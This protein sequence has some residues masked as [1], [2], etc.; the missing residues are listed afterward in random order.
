M[1][2]NDPD[3]KL[4]ILTPNEIKDL[5]SIPHFNHL[6]RCQY[7]ELN[8]DETRLME[9][10]NTIAT[11]VYFILLLGYFKVKPVNRRIQFRDSKD[12]VRFIIEQYF[13][14]TTPPKGLVSKSTHYHITN[15]ILQV[16]N[17]KR[18]NVNDKNQLALR[19]KDITTITMD[20]RYIMDE[21]LKFIYDHSLVL[22]PY[23]FFQGIISKARISERERLE[24]IIKKQLSTHCQD[25]LLALLNNN[26]SMSA[27]ASIKRPPKDFSYSQLMQEVASHQLIQP[28]YSE[29]K[30]ATMKLSLSMANLEYYGSLVEY[31]SITKLR[32][33]P[34][35]RRL[36][37][38][39]C[40]MH[41]R[42]QQIND[43][44]LTAFQYW[45][46]KHKQASKEYGKKQVVE[47]VDALLNDM[48]QAL[49]FLKLFVDDGVKD[50]TPFGKVRQSGFTQCP[51][52]RLM[53]ICSQ[54]EALYPERKAYEWRYFDENHPQ[55]KSILR[56]L[57]ISMDFGAVHSDS[58]LYNQITIS[59]SELATGDL[60]TF[61]LRLLTKT[62][63]PHIVQ[64]NTVI[65]KRYEF[66]LYYRISDAIDKGELYVK[67]S[68]EF[69]Q[70]EDDLIDA[71]F[72]K[73]H[74]Q[75]LI[76]N[77]STERLSTPIS[78]TLM[79]LE[80]QLNDKLKSLTHG[81]KN[82]ET[83]M[84]SLT[85]TGA[86]RWSRAL[87]QSNKEVNQPFFS[88]L[89]KTDII[90]VM[91]YV[92]HATG[93]LGAFTNIA[94]DQAKQPVDILDLIACILGN[95]TNYGTGEISNISDRSFS[96]LRHI[97]ESYLR[98]ETTHQ[99]ND[100]LSDAIAELAIYSHYKIED[101]TIYA[102]I[103]G[104][105]FE[106]R[107]G[108]F[109]SRYSSKYFKE[110]GVSA[111]TLS[112]NHIALNTV[113]I[114]ANEYEASFAFDLLYNNTTHI[115]PDVLSTDTHGTN[116]VNFAILDIFGYRFAPRYAGIKKVFHDLFTIDIEDDSV[117]S[118]KKPINYKLIKSEWD[119]IQRIMVSL[120]R[121]SVTQSVLIKK[122]NNFKNNKTLAALKEY[123]RLVKAIYLLDY[124]DNE[125]LRRYVQRTLN[126]GEA[127]HQLRRKI[128]SVN[129]DKFRGINDKAVALWNDCARVLANSII[130]FNS[131]ILSIMLEAAKKK[132]DQRTI[133]II[134]KLSPVAWQNINLN[135]SYDF[136]RSQV[137]DLQNLLKNAE[138]EPPID[139]DVTRAP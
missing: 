93:C 122:L 11:K 90:S 13:P 3:K 123:D 5:Y 65:P 132:G 113:M 30:A 23:S 94:P 7:F 127:Y 101:D 45:V 128:A 40:F 39:T 126:K 84:F 35:E 50:K 8:E 9:T 138:A 54:I 139:D 29:I 18:I 41:F 4:K 57:F 72:W 47:G 14:N 59:Q 48:K 99:C 82:N 85:S 71:Q 109:K 38:L 28:L 15:K 17:H 80:T 92:H 87:S 12:D 110:Q 64:D 49:P 27:L 37:Y 25:Q 135:G 67:N 60:S 103:D 32:R 112:C 120:S 130:Y 91:R 79:T 10:L 137:T 43:N 2:K 118:L 117:V 124:V 115:E 121:K 31:Y 61:D 102:S 134:S 74:K 55:I 111:L 106:T 22:P 78:E 114:G 19:I 70:L 83:S 81:L 34:T 58:A 33:F 66:F 16:R 51:R 104:Q 108:T 97:E 136:I 95:G 69:R 21:C 26:K 133:D 53:S 68:A 6:Q 89:Q 77:A 76:D 20:A 98:L 96:T 42:Y 105:K 75:A 125:S 131:V 56:K 100:I 36:L 63:K 44:L 88:Q 1:M 129:G 107:I 73:Q 62:A 52:V 116:Q 119:A 46:R 24:N 86:S